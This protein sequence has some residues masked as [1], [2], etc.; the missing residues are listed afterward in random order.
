ME[1][2]AAFGASLPLGLRVSSLPHGPLR[3]PLLP[4]EK[5]EWEIA[6]QKSQSFSKL[7]SAA[8]SHHICHFALIR[9]QSLG[10]AHIKGKRL[11]KGMQLLT[12]CNVYKCGSLCCAPE[13]NRMYEDYT[14]EGGGH[15]YSMSIGRQETLGALWKA[16]Y[17]TAYVPQKLSTEGLNRDETVHGRTALAWVTRERNGRD[18]LHRP[19][20]TCHEV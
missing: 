4:P 20:S 8:R 11:N 16:A 15:G 10:P 19:G 18:D 6:R 14:S 13:T 3:S 12:K 5:R 2:W 17:H 1:L 7:M 9:R